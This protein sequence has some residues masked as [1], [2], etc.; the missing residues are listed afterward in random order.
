[1]T[2]SVRYTGTS[3]RLPDVASPV[4]VPVRS[5]ESSSV[6]SVSFPVVPAASESGEDE[7]DPA[8]VSGISGLPVSICL[9]DSSIEEISAG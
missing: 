7:D 2:K 6:A 3:C 8:P 1:M 9:I 4:F 5:A